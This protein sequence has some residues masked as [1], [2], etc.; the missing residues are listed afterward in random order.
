MLRKAIYNPQYREVIAY[1]GD[2]RK[3]QGLTQSALGKR[4]R[5]SRQ[6]IQKIETCEVRLD[7]VRYVNLCRIL[8]IDAG[9]LLGRL[10]DTSEEDDPLF[11][12]RTESGDGV[13]RVPSAAD[14]YRF[15]IFVRLFVRH[16]VWTRVNIG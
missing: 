8:G 15:R 14:F 10:E 6:T 5:L 2:M 4:M 11:T 12:C 1:I 3:R 16:L 13:G 7:L 9:Q